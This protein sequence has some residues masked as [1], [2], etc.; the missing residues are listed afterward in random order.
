MS[1][2]Y[3]WRAVMVT[4]THDFSRGEK[5]QRTERF[6]CSFEMTVVGFLLK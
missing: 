6:L 1:E 4:L 3:G 5:S 2:W